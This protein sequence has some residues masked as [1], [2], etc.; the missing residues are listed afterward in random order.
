MSYTFKIIFIRLIL[1][2]L[3]LITDLLFQFKIKFKYNIRRINSS[4]FSL[5][6]II[7]IIA[8]FI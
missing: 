1:I 4:Y 5:E 2:L 8:I 6:I 7:F 3:I